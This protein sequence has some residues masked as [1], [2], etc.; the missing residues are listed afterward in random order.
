MLGGLAILPV[1]LPATTAAA[2]I[3]PVY[4]AIDAH[5]KANIAHWA[6]IK[7]SEGL[8][9]WSSITEQPCHDENDA[10]DTLIA[11]HG[12]QAGIPAHDRRG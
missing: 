5:R 9:D 2:T 4:S 8:M 3:D 10:F 6:A 11:A 12:R 1:V 7:S